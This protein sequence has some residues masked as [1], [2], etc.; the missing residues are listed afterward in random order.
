MPAAEEGGEGGPLAL[1]ASGGEEKARAVFCVSETGGSGRDY[2]AAAST[3]VFA[4]AGHAC[5]GGA[6]SG[7]ENGRRCAGWGSEKG[8]KGPAGKAHVGLRGPGP[9]SATDNEVG[10]A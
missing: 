3:V 7:A 8:M 2:E 9:L 10:V 4:A 1:A 6:A 5:G